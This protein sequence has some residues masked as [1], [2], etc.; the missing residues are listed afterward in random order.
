MIREQET[1]QT[2]EEILKQ[3]IESSKK[4]LENSQS[5]GNVPI[6]SLLQKK[7]KPEQVAIERAIGVQQLQMMG[8]DRERAKLAWTKADGDINK[9]IEDL[10]VT[11]ESAQDFVFYY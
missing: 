6:E 1:N 7:K 9:A 3:V 10:M 11:Q 8:F 2:E 5:K 4:D